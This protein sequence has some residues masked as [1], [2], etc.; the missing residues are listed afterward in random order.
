MSV[1]D[2]IRTRRCERCYG[3]M[4]VL[5]GAEPHMRIDREDGEDLLCCQD[6]GLTI[7]L[8]IDAPE[9]RAAA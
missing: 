9:G 5:L 1:S 2:M 4:W 3:Q 6:C 7:S 8:G